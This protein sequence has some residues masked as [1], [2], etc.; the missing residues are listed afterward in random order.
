[1]SS[2]GSMQNTNST[3]EL[4]LVQAMYYPFGEM[5]LLKRT[6]DVLSNFFNRLNVVLSI[7]PALRDNSR[8]PISDSAAFSSPLQTR[9][10]DPTHTKYEFLY[11]KIVINY[12]IIPI[13]CYEMVQGPGTVIRS[14]QLYWIRGPLEHRV[15]LWRT[16]EQV[17][18]FQRGKRYRSAGS[19]HQNPG[20]AERGH[21]ARSE[22]WFP[23][24]CS[25]RCSS[26]LFFRASKVLSVT[27]VLVVKSWCTC[28][29][30]FLRLG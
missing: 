17:A 7:T 6:T 25:S 5:W 13:G 19:G 10:R 26:R 11:H 16:G 9:R 1:M 28:D 2:Y 30:S 4:G 18:Y 14:A 21:L 8:S 23:I 15:H 29:Y 22:R 24:V 3:D 27:I 12:I 20:V